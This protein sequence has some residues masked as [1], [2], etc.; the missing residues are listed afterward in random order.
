M[1]TSVRAAAQGDNC[2]SLREVSITY[3]YEISEQFLLPYITFKT[4]KDVLRISPSLT[5]LIVMPYKVSY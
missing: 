2:G 4:L 3:A 1:T 5:W